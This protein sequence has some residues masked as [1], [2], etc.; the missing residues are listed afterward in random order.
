LGLSNGIQLGNTS[1]TNQ[2]TTSNSATNG[3]GVEIGGFPMPD[4]DQMLPFKPTPAN[5]VTSHPVSGGKLT[6]FE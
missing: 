4:I 5:V 2:P 1:G 6:L 3:K